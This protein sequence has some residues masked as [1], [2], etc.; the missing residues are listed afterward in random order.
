MASCRV[1]DVST[2][3]GNS[4]RANIVTTIRLTKGQQTGLRKIAKREDRS[5]TYIIRECIAER[6]ERDAA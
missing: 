3:R 5:V 6:L 4:D 1:H 2:K